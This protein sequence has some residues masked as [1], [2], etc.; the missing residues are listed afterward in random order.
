MPND[1][2]IFIRSYLIPGI[3]LDFNNQQ[4][5]KFFIVIR[6]DKNSFP[7]KLIGVSKIIRNGGDCVG[8]S[9]TLQKP[10]S[11]ETLYAMIYK[12]NGDR[13][14]NEDEDILLRG[15]ENL[16]IIVKFQVVK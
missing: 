8:L 10:V 12:D 4:N 3:H 2:Q 1:G 15:Y 9:I 6:K 7:E 13:I 5:S 16:P 11:N 14:F